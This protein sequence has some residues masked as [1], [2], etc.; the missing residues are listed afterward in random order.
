MGEIAQL[1]VIGVCALLQ[2]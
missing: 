1:D 2:W